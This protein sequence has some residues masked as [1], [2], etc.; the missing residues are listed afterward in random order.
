[1]K[2]IMRGNSITVT[3][4][5]AHLEN[6]GLKV[7]DEIKVTSSKDKITLTKEV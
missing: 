7:G 4:S 5:R 1:M 6:S 2:I 3:I